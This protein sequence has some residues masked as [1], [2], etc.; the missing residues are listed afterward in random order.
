[1]DKHLLAGQISGTSIVAG[2]MN[3]AVAEVA[4]WGEVQY[5]IRSVFDQ[6]GLLGDL[7]A[8]QRRGIEAQN[9]GVIMT[10]LNELRQ[11]PSILVV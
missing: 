5:G 2:I 1:M 4:I 6:S 10:S 7:N 3:Q 9:L 8:E 11:D